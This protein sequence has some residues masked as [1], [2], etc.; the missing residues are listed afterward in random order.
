MG[1]LTFVQW[2][3]PDVKGDRP[4]KKGAVGAGLVRALSVTLAVFLM[5]GFVVTVTNL[6]VYNF[7][8]AILLTILVSAVVGGVGA[9]AAAGIRGWQ[10]GGMT[11][12]VYGMLFVVVAGALLGLPVVDPVLMTLAM[13][14]LGTVGGIVGVNLAAVRKRTVR[15]RYLGSC[16]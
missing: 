13:A 4:F 10:H 12:L 6:S 15:R 5:M 1:K 9:G 3:K 8:Q 2:Q 11:G 7:S 16:K 14:V